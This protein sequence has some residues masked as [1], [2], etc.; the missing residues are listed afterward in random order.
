[1]KT[2]NWVLTA[3][4]F[5]IVAIGF[6]SDFPQMN[7][8]PI[9]A[10]KALIAFDSPEPAPLEITL[11][12]HDGE[13]LYYKRSQKR[14]SEYKKVFDFA[15]LGT[16]N[17]CVCVNFGNKSITRTVDVTKD[18]ILVGPPQRLYEPY[19]C[20][21]D[22]K[23]NV[24]MFN[25]PQKQVLVNIYQSGEHISSVKLGKELAIQKCL[26]LSRLEKGEYKIVLTDYFKDHVYMAQLH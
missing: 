16:G 9:E 2:K 26:D 19:F 4:A 18:K 6:A 25:C 12:N 23:L 14:Y 11:T 20:I 24:S 7:V 3:L 15:E 5:F 13:I 1:M 21:K 10:E 17:Y 8:V 22:N